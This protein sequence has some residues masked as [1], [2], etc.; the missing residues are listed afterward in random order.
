MI[1]NTITR[2]EYAKFLTGVKA[3]D[4][5]F[6]I[7]YE[8]IKEAEIEDDSIIIFTTDHGIP[9]PNMK[10]TLYDDGTGIAFIIRYKGNKTTGKA[11]DTLLSNVD[12]FPTICGILDLKIPDYVQGKSFLP[13]LNMDMDEVNSEIFSEV[14]Y[15]AA[16]EPQR[17][18]RTKRHK[19]IKRYDEDTSIV[20]CNIDEGESKDFWLEN[21][22]DMLPRDRE[23]LFDLYLDPVERINLINHACYTD[24]LN[25]L[26]NKLKSWQVITNDPILYGRP[27]IEGSMVM[28]RNSDP[29]KHEYE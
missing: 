18:I 8:A 21:N 6:G 11:I 9:Y 28:K 2:E 27:Y 14:N 25:E 13:V 1:D 5:C 15:H 22:I 17:C 23:M 20:K 4:K 16:Y 12:V 10:C 3:V 19:Y 29:R 7:V 24:I 26:K